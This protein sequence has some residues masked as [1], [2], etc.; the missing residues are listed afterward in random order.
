ME[1]LPLTFYSLSQA[2]DF[3]NQKTNSTI[4][5]N[6]L[7]SYAMEEKIRFLLKIEIKDNQLRKIGRMKQKAFFYPK[8]QSFISEI[9]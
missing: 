2:V 6:L 5:E 7:Y 1:L 8:I 9:M 3:I 4:K